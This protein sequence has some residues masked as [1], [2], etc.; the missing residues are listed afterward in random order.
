[1]GPIPKCP[2]VGIAVAVAVYGY[3]RFVERLDT[4]AALKCA[5]LA[6]VVQGGVSLAVGGSCDA[7]PVRREASTPRKRR[8]E[9][10]VED[11]VDE[12]AE[13]DA[14]DSVS[15]QAEAGTPAAH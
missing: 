1:M 13:E 6:M 12:D 14:D 9:T 3:L 15:R 2:V 4:F 7:C 8:L 10:I 5:L 11:P